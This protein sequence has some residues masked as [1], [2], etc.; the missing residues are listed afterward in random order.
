MYGLEKVN[1]TSGLDPIHKELIK[2]RASKINQCA[3]C[4]HMHTTEARKKGET[5]QR[6]YLLNAWRETN[7]FSE[8]ERAILELTEEITK[9]SSGVSE[10]T[11]QKAAALFT[12]EYLSAIIM[13]AVSINMWN[14]IAITSAFEVNPS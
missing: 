3:F 1:M 13:M 5:K 12:P 2:I 10:A 11:F 4:I 7:L 6:I 9:V 14:R 8:E